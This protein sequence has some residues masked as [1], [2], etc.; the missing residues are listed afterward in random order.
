MPTKLHWPPK[1]I[2]KRWKDV[3]KKMG[4]LIFLKTNYNT[5]YAFCNNANFVALNSVLLSPS[6]PLQRYHTP[7]CYNTP[8]VWLVVGHPAW[9]KYQQQQKKTSPKR[10]ASAEGRGVLIRPWERVM[11]GKEVKFMT[12]KMY[13]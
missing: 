1:T 5:N 9:P 7:C 4:F 12:F 6:S 8:M 3:K 11:K 2:K 10:H 13:Y